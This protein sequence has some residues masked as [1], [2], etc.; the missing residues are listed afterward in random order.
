MASTAIA[1]SCFPSECN[2]APLSN[3]P[4]IESVPSR[5]EKM[6]TGSDRRGRRQRGNSFA[7]SLSTR[8]MHVKQNGS[9]SQQTLL[10]VYIWLTNTRPPDVAV[11]DKGTQY[12]G[13]HYRERL[14]SG[15]VR[16]IQDALFCRG[17][18]I[19]LLIGQASCA[20]VQS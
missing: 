12:V 4:I 20:H 14:G 8:A 16:R 5:S 19:A 3:A 17:A 13:D 7:W 15:L 18:Q 11:L 9:M 10:M 2:H 6:I 1:T